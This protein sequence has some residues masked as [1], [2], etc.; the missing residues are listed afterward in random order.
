MVD[1]QYI[2]TTLKYGWQWT[3]LWSELNNFE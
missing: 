1:M 2:V 3:I